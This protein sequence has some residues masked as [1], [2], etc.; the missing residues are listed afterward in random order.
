M[1]EYGGVKP[2]TKN[3]LELFGWVFLVYLV[4]GLHDMPNTTKCHTISF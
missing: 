1:N 4:P 3:Y 2:K